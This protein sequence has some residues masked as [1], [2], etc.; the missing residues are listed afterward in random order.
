MTHLEDLL[1]LR[2]TETETLRGKVQE[3]KAKLEVLTTQLE[4]YAKDK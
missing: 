2:N 4:D 3:L 1:R